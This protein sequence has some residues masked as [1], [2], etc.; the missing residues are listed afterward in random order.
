MKRRYTVTALLALAAVVMLMQAYSTPSV[1]AMA[2][3]SSRVSDA[4]LMELVGG[5]CNATETHCVIGAVACPYRSGAACPDSE[6]ECDD[7]ATGYWEDTCTKQSDVKCTGSTGCW[8]GTI[9][10]CPCILDGCTDCEDTTDVTCGEYYR[11]DCEWRNGQCVWLD[12][13]EDPTSCGTK[14][15]C[16]EDV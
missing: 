11:G 5:L 4:A 2:K 8:D 9:W 13:T 1:Q 12:P 10:D 14:T 6:I 7:P 15:T 16:E 3:S